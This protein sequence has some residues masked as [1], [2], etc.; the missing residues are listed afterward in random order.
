VATS[1]ATGLLFGLAPV[2]RLCRSDPMDALRAGAASSISGLGAQRSGFRGV[3]VVAE[4]ALAMVLLVGAGLLIRS[5]I[6]LSSVD[7]GYNPANVLTFQ[8]SLPNDRYPD[9]RLKRFAEDVVARLRS[10]PGVEAAAYANQLPMV[11]LRDSG[12]GLWRTPDPQRK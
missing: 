8:V 6:K 7:A 10:V 3:L 2:F 9:A 12:G 1:I 4:I 11:G 5:F